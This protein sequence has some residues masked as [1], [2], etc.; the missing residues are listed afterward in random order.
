VIHN[1]L[2]LWGH[3]VGEQLIK[4]QNVFCDGLGIGLVS[5]GDR[6]CSLYSI[7]TIMSKESLLKG[8]VHFKKTFANNL[9][10]P[11]SSKM[12]TSFFLQSKR[13]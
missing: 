4:L 11:M 10:T 7:S 9:L 1:V 12:S 3:L 8:V 13:N 2:T 5:V 6:I